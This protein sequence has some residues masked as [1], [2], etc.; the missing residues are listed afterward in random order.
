M[1]IHMFHFNVHVQ[2]I[3]TMYVYTHDM[4][5]H[6][7]FAVFFK[8]PGE[9]FLKPLLRE[10]EFTPSSTVCYIHVACDIYSSTCTIMYV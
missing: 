8:V 7:Y 1:Y 2:Y 4:H 9:Y 5:T 10:F 6:V 3:H